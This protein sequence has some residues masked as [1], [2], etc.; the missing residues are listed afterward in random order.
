[1]KKLCYFQGNNCHTIVLRHALAEIYHNYQSSQ[2]ILRG[3][4][5][6]PAPYQVRGKLQRESTFYLSRLFTEVSLSGMV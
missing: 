1:M 5:V 4:I 2:L 6:I 3:K